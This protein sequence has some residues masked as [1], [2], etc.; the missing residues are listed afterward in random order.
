[1]DE[2]SGPTPSCLRICPWSD[3]CMWKPT[4]ALRK[5]RQM[6][7][8]LNSD[9]KNVHERAEKKPQTTSS[10]SIGK[11]GVSFLPSSRWDFQLQMANTTFFYRS[12]AS[13]RITILEEG[14]RQ[15]VGLVLHRTAL[16]LSCC[17]GSTIQTMAVISWA[18]M[19]AA[20]NQDCLCCIVQER[21]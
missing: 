20:E 8:G 1:M 16:V 21:K 3:E 15:F 6:T 17:S 2:P 10:C 4:Y 11:S 7:S 9:K 13:L 12:S 18:F 19:G 5:G 14:W